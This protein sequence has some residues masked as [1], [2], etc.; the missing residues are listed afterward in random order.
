MAD[1]LVVLDHRHPRILG[2]KANQP[3]P[4]TRN[5]QIDIRLQLEQLQDHLAVGVWNHLNPVC[6]QP[7]L[8]QR[9]LHQLA[10][11]HVA[12]MRLRAAA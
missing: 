4:A 6:R 9:L 10:Q 2:H 11:D 3:F 5:R 8:D 7:S 12:A 1:A